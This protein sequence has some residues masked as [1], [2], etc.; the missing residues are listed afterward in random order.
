MNME[1]S[2]IEKVVMDALWKHKARPDDPPE[3]AK[4][5]HIT[6]V[7]AAVALQLLD[8]RKLLPH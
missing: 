6:V 3:I 8:H 1:M 7:E 2:D 4:V 5:C